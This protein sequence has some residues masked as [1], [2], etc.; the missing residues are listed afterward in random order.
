MSKVKLEFEVDVQKIA[1]EAMLEQDGE[2]NNQIRWRV[3]QEIQDLAIDRLTAEMTDGIK[4]PEFVEKRRYGN[5]EEYLTSLAEKIIGER[6]TKLVEEAC[7]KWLEKSSQTVA[8][9]IKQLAEEQIEP[10][11]NRLIANML[12]VNTEN[13]DAEMQALQEE[14]EETANRAYQ[15]GLDTP[16]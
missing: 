13:V 12:V 8:Y 14:I 9:K 3:N 5:G 7:E 16:R 15:D 11:L 2:I 6:L 10:A 1:E 4:I